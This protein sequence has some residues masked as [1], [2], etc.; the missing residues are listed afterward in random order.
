MS[1]MKKEDWIVIVIAAIAVIVMIYSF[2]PWGMTTSTAAKNIYE[3][4]TSSGQVIIDVT[5]VEF[6]DGKFY[7]DMKFTT[8]TGDLAVY[9][10]AKLVTL[11][12]E[13]GKINPSG[14]GKIS[15]HH[16]SSMMTF[17][18]EKEPKSFRII[19][20]EIPDLSERVMEWQ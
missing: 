11:E 20:K 15:G 2:L 3:T 5:P 18:I 4:K 14:A 7:V 1:E 12:Y 19:I 10:L 6:K 13:S 16:S 17:N 8:H 9:D